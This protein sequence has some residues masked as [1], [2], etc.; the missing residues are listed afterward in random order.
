MTKIKISS[1][2][3]GSPSNGN[4]F[5]ERRRASLERYLKRTAQHPVLVL[6]PD[7]RE[8]LESGWQGCV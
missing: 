6:D 7:F 1:Q 5:V 4:D 3:E 2:S 8:F